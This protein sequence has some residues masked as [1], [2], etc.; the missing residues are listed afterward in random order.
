M[1]HAYALDPELVARWSS[2]AEFRFIRDK[3]GLGTPRVMLDAVKYTR[4]KNLV[5]TAADNLPLTDLDRSRLQELFKLFRDRR[6]RRPDREKTPGLTWLENAEREF[7]RREFAAVLAMANPRSHRGVLVSAPLD[8]SDPRW[9]REVG[10]SPARTPEELAK[11]LAPMLVNSQE[12]HL[13]DPHFGPENGR[14]RRV[15]EALLDALDDHGARPSVVCIHCGAKAAREFFEAKAQAMASWLPPSQ[16]VAFKR[17][18]ERDG[19]EDLHNRYL[20][21]DLGGVMLGVG[22]DEGKEGQTDDLLLLT[23][24]QYTRRWSQYVGAN[25]AFALVDEPAPVTGSK[26]AQAHRGSSTR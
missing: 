2:H 3:F 26:T 14:H 25:G 8:E 7:D 5:E 20:L 24:A 9:Q 10:A 13:V 11:V 16:T 15:L 12:I 6:S 1:I 23:P 18:K 22:L 17:W 19:G 21:T 4:W